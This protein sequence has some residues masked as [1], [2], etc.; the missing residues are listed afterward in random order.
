MPTIR[1]IRGSVPL[2]YR[3]GGCGF[4]SPVVVEARGTGSAN[5]RTSQLTE[6]AY[7]NLL[8]NALTRAELAPCP[9]CGFRS[10]DKLR[11]TFVKTLLLLW[12]VPVGTFVWMWASERRF[13]DDAAVAGIVCGGLAA[14][15]LVW[16][17]IWA[18]LEVRRAPSVVHFGNAGDDAQR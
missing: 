17:S 5:F 14:L 7:E 2:D 10:F 11:S 8:H 12:L 6:R 9:R 4:E 13:A 16:L 18:W 15:M 3:C 1:H